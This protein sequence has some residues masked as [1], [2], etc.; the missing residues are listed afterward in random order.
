MSLSLRH[1]IDDT[2]DIRIKNISSV[3][4]ITIWHAEDFI[5][6]YHDIQYTKLNGKNQYPTR[7]IKS[8]YVLITLR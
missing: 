1:C 2:V 3:N 7:E 8:R 4:V 6:E 5:S